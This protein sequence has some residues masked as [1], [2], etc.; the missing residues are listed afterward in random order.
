MGFC[1]DKGSLEWINRGTRPEPLYF[2]NFNL[3]SNSIVFTFNEYQVGPYAEGSF[4][5][6]LEMT[7]LKKYINSIISKKY[8]AVK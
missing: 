7:K 6:E 8:F 3:T 1:I 4:Q 2:R 5:V